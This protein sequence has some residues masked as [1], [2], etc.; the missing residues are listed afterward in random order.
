MAS[1]RPAQHIR[2]LGKEMTMKSIMV[3][4]GGDAAFEGR[5]QVG[6]DLARR[7]H[8][9]MSLIL[10]RPTQD[11]VAFDMFGGA[12]F[13]AEA[14]EAAENEREKLCARIDAR[15][16]AEDVPWDWQMFDGTTSDALIDAARLADVLVMSLDSVGAAGAARAWISD[17]VTAS[18]TPVLAVPA[19]A[20]PLSFDRAMVAYDGGF[21][22]ANA[23]RAAL[24][25]LQAASIVRISEIEMVPERFPVTDAATYLSRHGISAE[26]AVAA[27]GNQSVEERLLAEANAWAPD[28]LV[29]GAYSHG[30]WRETLFGG[31]TRFM[32]GELGIPVLLA[33]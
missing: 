20:T 11:Y 27:K 16:K 5:L 17:V 26:I 7:F 23:L 1:V 33:H 32:L 9:H 19:K 24:P 3:H 14:F 12:H 31:V 21:E 4:A 18:R 29:M 28:L 2:P 25:L 8:G 6:L 13:V 15:L 30:R 22:A 10:P